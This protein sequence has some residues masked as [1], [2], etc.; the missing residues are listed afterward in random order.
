[1]LI[2]QAQIGQAQIVPFESGQLHALQA[3]LPWGTFVKASNHDVDRV[4]APLPTGSIPQLNG[5]YKWAQF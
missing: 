4:Q 1:M 5:P 3:K 2:G